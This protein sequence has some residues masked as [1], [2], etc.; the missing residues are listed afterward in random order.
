MGVNPYKPI[1]GSM[2]VFKVVINTPQA[3]FAR[4]SVKK[5]DG[6][7]IQPETDMSL[8]APGVYTFGFQTTAN[9]PLTTYNGF[10]AVGLNG[11][12]VRDKQSF[13]LVAD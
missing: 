9:M 10:T 2:V 3:D 1:R 5:T 4:L 8:S 12:T 7:I 11:R 6:T 13:V